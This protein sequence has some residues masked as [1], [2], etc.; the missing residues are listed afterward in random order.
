MI[1]ERLEKLRKKMTER[2]IDAY[3][4]LSSDPH[5]S[6]Y[7]AD[8]YKTRK[9]ITGFSGSAGT[10]VILK[11]KA[12]LFTDGR[13]FIQAAKELEGSGVDLMKM[14]EEGVPT[15][16]E[17][18]QENVSECGKIGVDGLTLDYK[19]YYKWLENLGDRMIITDLDFVGEIWED[20]PEKPSSTA[21]DL[22]VKYCGK[23]TKTKLK[24]LRYIMNQKECDYN[25]IGSLDDICYLYNI[26]GNDVLYNPVVISYTLVGK[27]FANL[28][29]DDYKVDDDLKSKLNEQGVTIKPYEKIFED[30]KELPAK[31]V[32]F[33]D[34]DKTNVRIYNSINSN[35]RIMKGLQP[36]SFM[37]AH[38]NETEIKNQK[39][40]YI[41]DGVALVKFFNWVETGT[42]TGNVTEMSASDKLRYF[43][44]QGDLFKDLSFGTIAAYGENAALPHYAPSEDNPV[45]LQPKGLF[46]VDSG[47]Q[48]LDGT[49]DITRTVALGEL[50]ED[51]KL[52]YTLTLKSHIA[53]MTTIF[54]KGTKSSSLDPI[55]RR[56]IWQELLDFKHGTGHG[57]GF[58][59]NV[60]EGPQRISS[61]NNEIDMDEGMVTSD[62][63]GIYIEGSHGIRI[64]NIMHCIKVGDSQ[65]GEFLGF[66]SLSI[67]PIDTRPVIKERLTDFELNWLNN[68]NKECYEKLSPYLE[69]SDLEYLEE[70]TKAI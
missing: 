39:N 18:L 55:A 42:P 40:A 17:Y 25:F 32:L 19:T 57:V 54:P 46:L 21:F 59:L 52:H 8:Y 38:K 64:E 30:L 53:L 20:R 45:T 66:E 27:D 36:V 13:Y 22:D 14:G 33:L 1:T 26:R 16:V 12:A 69:G 29:I 5:T 2:N 70:Q 11:K 31:S 35:I 4:V 34:S 67:V 47:A 68:Y 9:Y 15:L 6:E 44:E 10:A 62:E 61:F 63:P 50:T 28:Y 23:D 60:H 65:F 49:T 43:R 24:E 48:Y 41:R 3:V 7:L 58:Y 56:P 51:E 37:K